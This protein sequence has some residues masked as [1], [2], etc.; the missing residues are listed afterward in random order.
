ML[1]KWLQNSELS[2]HV[3]YSK[4]KAITLAFIE[5][6]ATDLSVSIFEE[7][8]RKEVKDIIDNLPGVEL[9]RNLHE[10]MEHSLISERELLIQWSNI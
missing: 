7:S 4:I 3:V 6:V 10:C 5:P 1:N 9:Q 8:N 2:L